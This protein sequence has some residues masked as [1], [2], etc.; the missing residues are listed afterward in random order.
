M[1]CDIRLSEL[2]AEKLEGHGIV[3]L[4]MPIDIEGAT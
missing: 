1:C 4:L 3:S 2:R